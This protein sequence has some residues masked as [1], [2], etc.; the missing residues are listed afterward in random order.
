MVCETLQHR[1]RRQLILALAAGACALGGPA[2]AQDAG[3][4]ERI[5]PSIVAVGSFER[6][7]NPQFSFAGTGFA[8]GDGSLVATNEHVLP[9]TLNTERNETIAISV[10]IQDDAIQVRAARK[11]AS[12]ASAD[13]A[14]LRIDGPP[15]RPLRLGDSD[16]VREGE[17]YL[18]TGFPIGAV[19]GLFPVTH[20]AMIAAVTPIAIPAARIGRASCRGRV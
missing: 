9:K 14:L 13:L 4:I 15:L 8:V 18:F 17:S 19:L 7:R 12:D 11:V 10:R 1:G 5:K 20:R 16:G 6:T 3:T 2:S